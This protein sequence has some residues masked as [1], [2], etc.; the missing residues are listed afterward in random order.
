MKGVGAP[1]LEG[2]EISLEDIIIALQEDLAYFGVRAEDVF[3]SQ[4]QQIELAYELDNVIRSLAKQL[5]QFCNSGAGRDDVQTVHEGLITNCARIFRLRRLGRSS[6]IRFRA[7][8]EA[9]EALIYEQA[10]GYIFFGSY[11]PSLASIMAIKLGER[12]QD[13]FG[14]E[15]LT[16]SWVMALVEAV[17]EISKGLRTY[18]A[19]EKWEDNP[20]RCD[21]LLAMS[22]RALT[23][24]QILME[25]CEKIGAKYSHLIDKF[26][27]RLVTIM[28]GSIL[29][30]TDRINSLQLVVAMRGLHLMATRERRK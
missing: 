2:E 8:K 15:E 19:Q 1:E 20:D 4:K 9:I 30:I 13:T 6:A 25:E 26:L 21:E 10:A 12:P 14:C 28:N 16:G 11:K 24:C 17:G 29:Y 27:R 23:I 5:I 3:S 22:R 18:L 7:L